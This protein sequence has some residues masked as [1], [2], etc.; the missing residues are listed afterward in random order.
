MNPE[1]FLYFKARFES[2]VARREAG[3]ADNLQ[4]IA[5]GQTLFN[6]GS[7]FFFEI[8]KDFDNLADEIKKE[9]KKEDV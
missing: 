4:R 8:E 5:E 3:S 2:L 1:K 9:I 6:F 7:D